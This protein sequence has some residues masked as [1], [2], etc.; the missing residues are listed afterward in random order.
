MGDQVYQM[1][2]LTFC[3]HLNFRLDVSGRRLCVDSI[4]P[5]VVSPRNGV[6]YMKKGKKSSDN[7]RRASTGFSKEQKESLKQISERYGVKPLRAG[8]NLDRKFTSEKSREDDAKQQEKEQAFY[9]GLVDIFGQPTL[10]KIET[11]VYF[12]LGALLLGFIGSGLA[13]ASEAFFKASQKEIPPALDSF[14]VAVEQYF[15]PLLVV[16]LIL[17]SILGVYK[18]AQLNAGAA[19]YDESK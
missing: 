5:S 13:I 7:K 19:Q 8:D 9:R 4:K 10:D 11:A 14:A 18:Q 12:I 2:S 3:N 17:S 16:F 15:T 6:V 1:A